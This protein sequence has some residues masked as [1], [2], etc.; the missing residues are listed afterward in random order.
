[1]VI[2]MGGRG[3]GGRSTKEIARTSKFPDTPTFGKAP[4]GYVKTLG[5]QTAP[6]GYAWYDN[7]QS[8]LSGKRKFVLVKE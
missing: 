5:A 1:M 3:S 4:K 8:F 6:N 2:I 7:G